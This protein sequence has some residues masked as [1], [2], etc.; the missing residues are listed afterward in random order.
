MEAVTIAEREKKKEERKERQ[1]GREKTEENNKRDSICLTPIGEELSKG[2]TA[3]L[4]TVGGRSRAG[5]F[6]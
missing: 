3:A 4:R 1:R 5:D 2:R 6:L